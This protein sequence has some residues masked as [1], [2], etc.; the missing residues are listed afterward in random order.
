MPIR[1]FLCRDCKT[2]FEHMQIKSDD[3][4]RCPKCKGENLST[5]ISKTSFKL[6]GGGWYQDGY[7]KGG[8]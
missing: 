8:K 7:S 3:K 4:A 1:E 6:K 2:K 5:L